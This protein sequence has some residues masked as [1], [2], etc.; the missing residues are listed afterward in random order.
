M[1][2]PSTEWGQR[3]HTGPSPP[4][5]HSGPSHWTPIVNPHHH[6]CRTTSPS[7]YPRHHRVTVMVTAALT[8]GIL[9][10]SPSHPRWAHAGRP[11]IYLSKRIG[12]KRKGSKARLH[13][14]GRACLTVGTCGRHLFGRWWSTGW[15]SAIRREAFTRRCYAPKEVA[16]LTREARKYATGTVLLYAYDKTARRER[17]WTWRTGIGI[18]IGIGI[19]MPMT[20]KRGVD[21]AHRL[22][23]R[24]SRHIHAVSYAYH[25]GS[26]FGPHVCSDDFAI[27]TATPS[28]ASASAFSHSPSTSTGTRTVTDA[29]AAAGESATHEERREQDAALPGGA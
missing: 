28:P 25:T 21:M 20:R 2:R 11:S 15:C 10:L 6:P 1:R 8:L 23:L 13:L 5:L 18:G 4:P 12:G 19:G 24:P 17:P 16:R 27:D 7:L 29:A 3:P 14:S 26:A 9:T 22:D